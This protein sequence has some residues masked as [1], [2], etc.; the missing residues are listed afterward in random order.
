MPGRQDVNHEARHREIVS[1]FNIPSFANEKHS[2]TRHSPIASHGMRT[3]VSTCQ[4][5]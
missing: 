3:N 5:P 1:L 2:F 4:M